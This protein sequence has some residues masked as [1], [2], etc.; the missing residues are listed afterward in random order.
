[1]IGRVASAAVYARAVPLAAE[2]DL[3]SFD[4]TDATPL[5]IEREE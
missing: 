2:L 5:K 4:H 3:P 1:V